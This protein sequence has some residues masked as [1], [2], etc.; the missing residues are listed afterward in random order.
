MPTHLP[1][2]N[3]VTERLVSPR[4]PFM[5]IR[6]LRHVHGQY[7][8]YGQIINVPISINTMV[9]Q[10][11]RDIDDE[12]CI[13]VHI[14]R[15]K[16][17]K[18][19]FVHGLVKK[20]S[21]KAWLVYLIDKPL[22]T[23]Y[24]ITIADDFLSNNVVEK[25]QIDL[26]EIS[27]EI[28][29]EDSLV[30]QQQT[31]MWNDE[32]FLR[33]APG[34]Q[35]VPISLLFDEHAE[36]LSFPTIYLGQFRKFRDGLSVTP[37]QI[38]TSEL[39]RTDRRAVTPHHL[40]YMAMKILRLRVR[41]S[42]T[43]AFKHVGHNTLINREQIESE[44]YINN[45]LETNLAFLKSV[46]NSTWYWAERKRDLF[47][48]MRQLGKPTAFLTLSANEIGWSNLL[49]LLFK[50]KSNG[51][52]ISAEDLSQLTF[53]EK[54]TLI[55]ED[56][57]TCAI[58]FNKMV[59][60]LMSILQ[61]KQCTPFG[62]YRVLH[63]FKRIEFQHRGSPHA[64]ILLWLDNAPKDPLGKDYSAAIKLIDELLSVST[65]QASGNIK[66]QTHKY[67]FTCYKRLSP[68]PTDKCRFEAPFLPS[69]STV[70][71]VPMQ[72]DE[73]GFQQFAQRYKNIRDNFNTTDFADIDDFYQKNNIASD[74]EYHLILRAGISRP[75]V[76]IKRLPSEKW[77]NHFNP[78]IL[79]KL[80]SNMDLQL[81]TEE[82]S[83]AQYV[84]DYVNKTNRGVSN[85]Q[86]QIINI[87]DEHPEFDIVEITRKVSV[88]VINN[89]EMTSQEA[90]WFLLREPMSKCSIKVVYIPTVW[91]IER[92]RIRKAQKELEELDGDSTDIWKE[93]CFDKYEKR[94]LHLKHITL[95]QF[96]SKY[97]KNNKGDFVLRAVPR[98]I[99][100]R[101]YDMANDI[102]DYKREMVT[103]HV[104]FI[105][106]E[107]EILA[108]LKF[109]RIYDENEEL[110]LQRR[111]DFQSDLDIE[112][113]IE[114]CRNLCREDELVDTEPNLTASVLR[115]ENPFLQLYQN[116]NSEV[117][118]DLRLA[119]LNKLGVIAK[120]K[121]NLMDTKQFC[122]LMRKANEK[123]K[124]L[125]LHVI[126]HLL[127]SNTPPL[128]IFFTGP[129]GSGKTFVIKLLMEIYNRFTNTDGY[130]NAY[131]TCAST[132]KAAVAID[133]S[134][135][136]TA[137]KI[138]L[139][140]LLP[141]SLE[142]AQ[143]YRALFKYIK[144]LIVDEVSMISA[145]LLARIDS[146]LKQIT[147]NFE[148]NFGALDIILI[149]D[150]RQLPPVRGTPIYKQPK[151]RMVGPLFGVV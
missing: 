22:Y 31:L 51:A 11:P 68:R 66:L 109:I 133:G 9:R 145:E 107:E 13:Y 97:S 37:F 80:Q 124:G 140:K 5:Q 29:I 101:N 78:F 138:S 25:T 132:G 127:T 81:I 7:G 52:H 4:I 43:I 110:L 50:L 96:V 87:M 54:S 123:Q 10:L 111:K 75:R 41:D 136:H 90:A 85:L 116:P 100:Y 112:K 38:A 61:S 121:Q 74:N 39:R 141:L 118:A 93:D 135:V 47:V 119:T 84:V 134:T 19:S 32:K 23:F 40:L 79:N 53:I 12:H 26:D 15:K 146:R 89:V 142:V 1:K 126:S 82:Y 28:P 98:I 45:C 92:Q 108:E 106:E 14:K 102:N 88:D 55:N 125:L 44:A 129:A 60:V 91:P 70:I 113:T 48:M 30:A 128:Q 137:L 69:R 58:Y 72:H 104:P 8:I 2:L 56:S 151:Q 77:Y 94:P 6:R 86:R 20:Q 65:A 34:E 64:H 24:N 3:L 27:E 143:Q 144:V 76:F 139:S 122:Q 105:N 16:I 115:D 42:L 73:E 148:T 150:L 57:V 33:I 63:Y 83:C 131:I 95:A 71:L 147:G 36:E 21:V 99:R 18:A 120:K 103:L 17:H 130:C 149:G 117:N 62:Q 46:P 35:N 67:T 114:I 49:T 59:N